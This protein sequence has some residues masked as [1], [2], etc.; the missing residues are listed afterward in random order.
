MPIRIILLSLLLM[1]TM[2]LA[3]SHR[4]Y[5]PLI[6]QAEGEATP[7]ARAVLQT[8]HRMV[9][10]GDIIRGACWDYLNTAFIRAGY[11]PA[12]RQVVYRRPQ[13][14]PYADIHR[15]QPGDWLYYINHSYGDIEHS[16]LFIGWLNRAQ[17]KGLILSYGGEHRNKP[18]RYRAYDLSSVYQIVRPQ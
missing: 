4:D 18:G 1:G 2:L 8:A 14:G 3:R 16:G 7:A 9:Q 17:K 6:R 12:K 13:S 5:S 11:P 10:R 15:I